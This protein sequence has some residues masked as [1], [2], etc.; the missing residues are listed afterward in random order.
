MADRP[1]PGVL[2]DLLRAAGDRVVFEEP[3]RVTT[4]AQLLALTG[5]IGGGLARAGIKPGDGVA[6]AVGVT[7]E[8][9]ATVLAAHA[10]GARVT[11]IRPGLPGR[12]LAHVLG[13]GDAAVIV[14][15][16]RAAS[17]PAVPHL[18]TVASLRDGPDEEP[19]PLARPDDIARVIHTSGSTGL[20]K[21]ALQTYAALAAGWA[22]H[23]ERWPLALRR[24]APRLG[25]HL[26]FGTLAS[27]VM[28]EYGTMALAAGGT[29]VAAAPDLPGAII[30]HR[31]T[32]TV[33]TVPKL[34]AV[35]AAARAARAGPAT[36]RALM[37]S[38][39]PL[40]PALLAEALDV[41]GPVVFHG[42][43]QTE[44]GMISMAAPEEMADPRVRASVGRPPA[45]NTVEIRDAAGHPVPPGDIG[46]VFV[47]TPVQACGYLGDPAES[48]A[49]FTDG[50]VRTRD[51]G[52]VDPDGYL[53]LAGRTRDV[54]IV[55]ANVQY[56]VPIERVLAAHPSVAEACVVGVPSA[57]TG[58]AV[59]AYV[60]PAAGDLDLALL[61]GLVRAE[62]GADAVPD[63][64]TVI[65]RVPLTPAGKPDR[66][67][68]R[69]WT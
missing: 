48:A 5:R 55:N 34:R 57:A 28:F 58:E 13:Q 12:H 38:G 15:A 67:A 31:A 68:L 11:G 53:H 42:Y 59:H 2:L 41:L 69:R 52:R 14:D 35:V 16:G 9:L 63:R 51:L 43:G 65:D 24:L 49:V 64:I 19:V 46:E 36:L 25:R 1:Y 29:L 66:D 6:L 62:L 23:P 50:W 30:R 54:I 33:I 26:V 44:A 60:V 61:R 40:D 56:A 18:R 21:G 27:Q 17:V 20:P 32:S 47:R 8:A 10:A 37:V 45:E 4:G 22:P 7:A 3:D 39:S